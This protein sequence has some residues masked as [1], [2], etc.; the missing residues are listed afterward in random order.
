MKIGLNVQG[1]WFSKLNLY[2]PY[3]FFINYL[4]QLI[5]REQKRKTFKFVK[6]N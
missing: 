2:C 6:S 5:Q 1:I 4:E 3:D